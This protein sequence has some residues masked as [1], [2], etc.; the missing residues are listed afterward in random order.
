MI[1]R[2]LSHGYPRFKPFHNVLQWR[3]SAST[4]EGNDDGMPASSVLSI[5]TRKYRAE[6]VL[7]IIRRLEAEERLWGIKELKQ[8]SGCWQDGI[9]ALY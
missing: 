1:Q 8:G 4:A 5:M 9:Q 3:D 2:L 6:M 7:W